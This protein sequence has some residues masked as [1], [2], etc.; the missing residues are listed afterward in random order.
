MGSI[1]TEANAFDQINSSPKGE[2]QAAVNSWGRGAV[3]RLSVGRLRSYLP[4]TSAAPTKNPLPQRQCSLILLSWGGQMFLFAC[5][6]TDSVT[7]LFSLK[8][9]MQWLRAAQPCLSEGWPSSPWWCPQACVRD[10][11]G[12][13]DTGPSL[14]ASMLFLSG[15]GPSLLF[16]PDS[17]RPGFEISFCHGLAV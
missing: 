3:L 10:P 8:Q 15:R 12:A 7:P 17:D 13:K 1:L 14:R 5:K 2:F 16:C 6:M 11:C 4:A 9:F